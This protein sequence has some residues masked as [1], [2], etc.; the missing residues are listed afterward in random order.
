MNPPAASIQVRRASVKDAAAFARIMGDPLVYPGLM[1]L[2]F[3]NEDQWQARLAETCAPG[4][5]DLPLAAELDGEVVGTAGLH[6]AGLQ[7]RRRHVMHLG[8]SVASHA[9]GRGV[10]TA[11]MAA[12]C[13][14]A[15]QWAGILRLELTVFA[16]NERAIRLYRRFGFETEGLLRAFAMRDGRYVDVFA[17]AR[18]H[19]DPPTLPRSEPAG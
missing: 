2:P 18:L 7:L 13:H 11:L 19:P 3:T 14:Y 9:Q 1:Q 10:G 6:P 16:D 17:M 12:M 5:A 15:D 4:K 8:I